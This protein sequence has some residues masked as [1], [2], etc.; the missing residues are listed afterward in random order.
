[1]YFNEI[2]DFST[3]LTLKILILYRPKGDFI[4]YPTIL[5]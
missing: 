4:C 2:K 5:L 3:I 1:M